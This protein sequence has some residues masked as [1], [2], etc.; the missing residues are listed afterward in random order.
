MAST[1]KGIGFEEIEGSPKIAITQGG[2]NA[3][4]TFK[5]AWA[6]W[7]AFARELVGDYLLFGSTPRLE[8]PFAFPGFE[9]A[10]VDHVTV[11]PFDPQSPDGGAV[12]LGSATNAYSTGA[13]ITAIY[14]TLFAANNLG[15]PSL[16]SVPQHT[17]LTHSEDIGAEYLT[18][19]GRTWAWE[20]DGTSVADDVNPGIL[21]ATR[22][23]T[24]RWDRIRNPPWTN[25]RDVRGKINNAQFIDSPT[26]TL[27]FLGARISR[28]F[29]FILD[30]GL[31]QLDYQFSERIVRE[32]GSSYGWNYFYRERPAGG[33][34]WLRIAAKDAAGAV[35][36]T[37]PYES[38]DF[39]TLFAY[40]G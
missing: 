15:R 35:T 13:K 30:D 16:P 28:K 27:L 34:H 4:R 19:P 11:E 33:V 38:A 26:G 5:V 20:T 37:Y 1:P 3:T 25:I 10:I 39:S 9:N 17:V 32:G 40:G 14:K 7:Q 31:W 2:V 24:L 12:T 6:D 36:T 21:V 22:I 29:H 23:I 18:T 8:S